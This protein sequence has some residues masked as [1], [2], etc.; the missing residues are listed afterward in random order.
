MEISPDKLI[1]GNKIAESVYAELKAAI[2]V[3]PGRAPKV[4]FIRVGED[5]SSKFYVSK[6]QKMAQAIGMESETQVLPISTTQ[7]ELL[8]IVRGHNADPSVDGILV[9]SPLPGD[10]HEPTIFN[11]IDPAKDVDGFNVINSGKLVQE[12]PDCF[13]AC[14]PQGI[15]EMLKR[16]CIETKGKKVVV[17]GRSLIVGKPL[18]LLL[19]RK[20]P[21]GDA[22]VT[23]CHSRSL[24]MGSITKNADILIAAVGRPNTVTADMVKPGAIVIDVGV[25]RVDDASKKRGYRIVGDVDFEGVAPIASKI[26]PVPGGVGPMT[27]AT[28]MQNTLKAYKL[29]HP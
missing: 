21:R 20:H 25:N 18:A 11:E 2:E 8:E 7:E 9:Q 5:P 29:A 10:I 23:I 14:T 24:D 4:L 22:T 27:V 1:D 15:I 3:L 28:L 16:E 12:D 13:V 6:K 26:T 19:A 17:I